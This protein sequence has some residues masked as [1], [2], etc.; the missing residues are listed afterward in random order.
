MFDML[1]WMKED[2]IVFENLINIK[3]NLKGSGFVFY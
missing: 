1:G 3:V 2:V